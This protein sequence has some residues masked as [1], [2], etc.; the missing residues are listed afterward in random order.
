MGR[1]PGTIRRRGAGW[2]VVLRVEGERHQFGP[3][4]DPFLADATRAE[5]EEW[6]WRKYREIQK[7]AQRRQDGLPGPMPVSGLFAEYERDQLPRLAPNT[8]RTYAATLA[9]FR[10]FFVERLGDLRVDRIRAPHIRKYLRWREDRDGVSARTLAKDRA[11][12]HAVFQY[13]ARDM[14]LIDANPVANVR[15]PKSDERTPIILTPEEYER[16]IAACD[17]PM[18]RMYVLLLGETGARCDSEALWLRWEDLDLEEGFIELVSGREGR[19]TKSGK[20]RWVPVTPRLRQALREHVLRFRGAEYRG[21]TS[22]WVFHHV[23]ARR[24]AAAGER[25]GSFRRGFQAALRRAKLPADLHQHDLRH[26]R[27]TTWLA[28]GRDLMH[29]KEAMG[30][31]TVKVTE[32]YTHLARE[33]LRALV[34]TDEPVTARGQG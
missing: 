20:S 22:P 12:L 31:S 8:R 28:E 29:V 15:P 1:H 2:Q 19:R 25:I 18:L 16:L 24:R 4:T 10:M 34:D 33:H 23:R 26:R 14:E 17:D 3:R 11:T 30:H 27:V 21:E 7:L 5:V 32:G 9:L 6:C 13:A